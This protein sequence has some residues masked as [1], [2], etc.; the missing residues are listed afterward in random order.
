MIPSHTYHGD[1]KYPLRIQLSC[2]CQV[3]SVTDVRVA[4]WL[5]GE[6]I[7]YGALCKGHF[8]QWNAWPEAEAAH[9]KE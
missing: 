2:G 3:E 9:A 8:A 7:C 4:Y 1:Q 5:I 6:A